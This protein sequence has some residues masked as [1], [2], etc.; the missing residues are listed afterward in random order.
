MKLIILTAFLIGLS[1]TVQSQV[2][3]YKAYEYATVPKGDTTSRPPWLKTN[4]LV[5][6]NVG[7]DIIKIYGGKEYSFSL[8]KRLDCN[9]L[10]DE[11]NFCVRYNAIDDDGQK[12]NLEILTSKAKNADGKTVGVLTLFHKT[13]TTM[14]L[15]KTQ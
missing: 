13:E 12:I 1:C 4:F 15:M 2:I 11:E 6:F 9:P 8:I 10:P 14:Y 3:K 5:V 7:D